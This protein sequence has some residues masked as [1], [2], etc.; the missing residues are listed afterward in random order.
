MWGR[1]EAA[2]FSPIKGLWWN[3]LQTSSA[4]CNS[5]NPVQT[6]DHPRTTYSA[7]TKLDEAEVAHKAKVYD[8]SIAFEMLRRISR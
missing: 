4:S 5:V 7:G 3:S 2:Y 8:F 1:D 6:L